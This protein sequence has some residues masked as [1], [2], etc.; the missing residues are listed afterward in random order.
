MRINIIGNSGCGK[1]TLGRALA[2]SLNCGFHE[3]DDLH[4]G[5]NWTERPLEELRAGVESIVAEQ[6]WVI[7]GNYESK[8]RDLIWPRAHL[9]VWLDFSLPRSLYQ[10]FGRTVR[11]AVYKERLWRAGNVENFREIFFSKE[12]LF[13]WTIKQHH[14]RRLKNF[15]QLCAAD[16]P[17]HFRL[18][19]PKERDVWWK[20]FQPRS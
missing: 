15:L 10:L 1:T 3:L 14:I 20:N 17:A 13:L 11:R 6:A 18:C 16:A 8:V 7:D 2:D 9:V 5:P 19:S 4:W 12:S